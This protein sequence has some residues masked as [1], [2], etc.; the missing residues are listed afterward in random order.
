MR[1]SLILV[2]LLLGACGARFPDK[3]IIREGRAFTFDHASSVDSWKSGGLKVGGQAWFQGDNFKLPFYRILTD[4]GFRSP[5]AIDLGEGRWLDC[6][7]H[8][9]KPREY[10]TC[11]VPVKING[12]DWI[13]ESGRDDI[14]S[15]GPDAAYHDRM[16]RLATWIIVEA[17][18]SGRRVPREEAEKLE[19]WKAHGCV[20][21]AFC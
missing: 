1:K 19:W 5:D 13:A 16:K 4:D 17:E 21:N 3:T 20:F 8:A 18:K 2:C 7:S 15:A 6:L 9:D 11:R 12:L 14:P 10:F